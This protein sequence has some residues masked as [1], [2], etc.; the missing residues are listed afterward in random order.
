M[1]ISLRTDEDCTES[2]SLVRYS[3][4]ISSWIVK[5]NGNIFTLMF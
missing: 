3:I 2:S 1:E 4:W 5:Y